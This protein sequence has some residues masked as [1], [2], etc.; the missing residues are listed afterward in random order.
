MKKVILILILS[1]CI[2]DANAQTGGDNVYEF[3]NLSPNAYMSSLGGFNVSS[4]SNDPSVAMFNPALA[5]S[6]SHG[7]LALSYLNYFAGINYGSIM[8]SHHTDSSGTFSAGINYLNYGRFDRADE[9]GNINGYFNASEY[10]FNIIYTRQL[11]SSFTVGVNL[12]P[13]IS[14]LESYVSLGLAIDLGAFYQ[15]NDGMINAGIVIRNSGFQLTTYSGVREKLP[16]EIV[17]GISTG[18]KHAPL[19]FS[20]TARH[21]EKYDL[22]HTYSPAADDDP[23]LSKAGEIAENIMRHLVFGAELM[24]TD[25]FFIATGFNYQRRKEMMLD[26]G[27]ATVGFSLGAGIKTSSFEIMISRAKYHIAGS[28]TS[29]SL[30]LK[31]SL[32][33]S[34]K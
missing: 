10:A 21:L 16:F 7:S 6:K 2:I 22:L 17:A 11:D 32:F 9:A 20:L 8:Y 29:F 14:Q 27:S 4:L 23:P 13:V 19:R 15:S 26:L 34:L 30:L 33:N 5:G 28:S 24:P 25:N 3:L 31:P 12:K 1:Y 18:L